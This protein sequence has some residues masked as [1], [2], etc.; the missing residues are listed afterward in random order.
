[1]QIVCFFIVLTYKIA[2]FFFSSWK[3]IF[4]AKCK[5]LSLAFFK[6][7]YAKGGKM[8]GLIGGQ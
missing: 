8:I 6:V 3:F 4:S 1:M 2:P 5:F 7:V